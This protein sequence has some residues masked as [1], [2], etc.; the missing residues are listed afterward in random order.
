MTVRA[1]ARRVRS[2]VGTGA[3]A[4]RAVLLLPLLAGVLAM[5]VLLL[6]A[7]DGAE[8]DPMAGHAGHGTPSAATPAGTAHHGAHALGTATTAAVVALLPAVGSAMPAPTAAVAST[9]SSHGGHGLLEV[10]LAVLVGV[11]L[12]ALS[13]WSRRV[14][15][16]AVHGAHATAVVLRLAHPPPRTPPRL[17]LCVSRT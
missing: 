9:A 15:P 10:C 2:D 5:H 13:R 11:V 16:A 1:Y 3:R 4:W 7:T 17:L 12:L 14:G 8:A 6:C